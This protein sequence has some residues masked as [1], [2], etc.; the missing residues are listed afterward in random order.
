VAEEVLKRDQ[1]AVLKAILPFTVSDYLED[2]TTEASREEFARLLSKDRSPLSLRVIPL[3]DEFP[4]ELLP[5]A[6]RQAY[7]DVGRYIV[8][9]S[10][11]MIALWE[12]DP[13]GGKGGT[14]RTVD[15]AREVNC[16]T[17]VI[18]PNHPADFKTISG[19]STTAALFKE[20]DTFNSRITRLA[21]QPEY[22]KNVMNQIFANPRIPEGRRIS[23]EVIKLIKDNL[24]PY[25]IPASTLAKHYQKVYR[26]AGLLVFW[27][28][29][30]IV[31]TVSIGILFLH[32]PPAVFLIEFILL[33]AI[34]ALI[35][36]AGR[37]K[38]S[39]HNWME[40]RFLTERIR[41]GFFLAACGVER[42]PI[43]V[44]RRGGLAS[45]TTEWMN[46]AL[47]EIWAKLPRLHACTMGNCRLLGDFV[48]K[49]W[50]DEQI[51]FHEKTFER[52]HR[53]S[54]RFEKAGEVVFFLAM[55]VAISHFLLPMA[56]V[57]F[58]ELAF[59]NTLTLLS[60]VLPALG[61]TIGAIRSHRE[62]KRLAMRSRKMAHELRE[63]KKVFTLITPGKLE[64]LLRGTEQVMIE[65]SRD[66]LALMTF[67]EL[68]KAV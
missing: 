53:R 31:S 42:P 68:H 48:V 60:L 6:R 5:A 45:E 63:L 34:S 10:D 7:E 36:Y 15:Y 13:E 32:S 49:A 19:D 12:E 47:T 25:Y 62:Y 41:S 61:A 65:E 33:A 23:A 43:L 2:F 51:D 37:L 39:H 4:L 57:R 64:G 66:W 56:F 3:R 20:I 40:Y 30:A 29:F 38:R 54:R 16:P 46:L 21:A 14:A 67:A 9:H 27:S 58:H 50:L 11:V 52:N 28:A 8:R 17:Y 22:E 26:L 55:A 35:A 44:G 24:I 1:D 18:N 59:A